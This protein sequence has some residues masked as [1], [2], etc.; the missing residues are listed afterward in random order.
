MEYIL[1]VIEILGYKIT[2]TTT[3]EDGREFIRHYNIRSPDGEVVS[4]N[5]KNLS[6]P[7]QLLRDIEATVRNESISGLS[8]VA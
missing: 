8:K 6:E 3:F 5:F 7:L 2:A 4:Q 1:D